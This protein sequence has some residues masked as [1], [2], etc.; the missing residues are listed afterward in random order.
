MGRDE[1][2]KMG[3]TDKFFDLVSKRSETNAK[4]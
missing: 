4:R 2:R 3:E 1:L